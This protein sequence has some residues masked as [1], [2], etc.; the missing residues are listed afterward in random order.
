LDGQDLVLLFLLATIPSL[1]LNLWIWR[2]RKYGALFWI[3]LA[4]GS[5]GWYT[6]QIPKSVVAIAYLNA[7]GIQLTT[8]REELVKNTGILVMGAI[9][10]G[11]FEELFKFIGIFALRR[12]IQTPR[13]AICYGLGAGSGAGILEAVLLGVAAHGIVAANPVE[14]TLD[15]LAGPAERVS[16]TF[17]HA[18][19]TAIFAYL[20]FT[21]RRVSG[22]AAAAG[23]HTLVDFVAPWLMASGAMTNI[24][25]LEAVVA[26]FT[27]A[28]YPPLLAV[29]A[30]IKATPTAIPTAS[31]TSEA[32]SSKLNRASTGNL[33]A[34]IPRPRVETSQEERSIGQALPTLLGHSRGRFQP[35]RSPLRFS[36]SS[37]SPGRSSPRV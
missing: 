2:K 17:L 31:H 29:Y 20:F 16:A 27:I 28:L 7:A 25:A 13:D 1:A 9:S 34:P 37:R 22:F 21:K 4:I 24:W 35:S 33:G 15:I 14:I 11:V 30:K 26:V 8:P 12:R 5:V 36:C 23:Y 10:A 18:A 6:A 3:I 32:Q 19:L